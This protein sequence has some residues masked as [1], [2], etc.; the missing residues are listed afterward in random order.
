VAT[1]SPL[2]GSMSPPD[3][4]SARLRPRRAGFCFTRQYYFSPML[5]APPVSPGNT[6]AAGSSSV[7]FRRRSY[8]SNPALGS[9]HHRSRSK[10]RFIARW[11]SSEQNFCRGDLAVLMNT[12]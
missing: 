12:S 9:R 5:M 6:N 10:T 2:I 4:P 7:S 11:H 8:L 3:Y 1:R